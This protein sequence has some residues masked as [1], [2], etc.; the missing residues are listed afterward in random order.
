MLGIFGLW[1]IFFLAGIIG[2]IFCMINRDFSYPFIGRWLKGKLFGAQITEVEMEEREDNWVSGVCHATAILQIWGVIT[3]FIVWFS[4][5][6][7]SAKLRLQA[8]QAFFYQLIAAVTYIMVSVF[9]GLLYFIGI[10]GML[11]FGVASNGSGNDAHVPPVFG[12]LIF[13][14]FGGMMLFFLIFMI[15]VPLYYL[16]AAVASV[17]TIRGH[18]FKY[19]ILGKIIARRINTSSQ[20]VT[21]AL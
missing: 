20:K 11:V 18:D 9:G 16:L 19:P 21:P 1:G 17:R 8:L 4:Q 7:R 3:P 6:G 13:L 14:F 2:A 5:K 10:F 15:A 12:I